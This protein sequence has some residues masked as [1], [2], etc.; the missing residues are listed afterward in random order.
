MAAP[1]L[2][3]RRVDALRPRPATY[4]FRDSELKGFC[5]RVMPSGKKTYLVASQHRGERLWRRL[6]DA[7]AIAEPAAREMARAELAAFREKA[8]LLVESPGEI[9]FEAVAEEVFARYGRHWKPRT[10]AVNRIYLRR[11]ILPFFEGRAIGAIAQ[12][13]VEAWFASLHATPAAA[14]RSVPIL[15][16]IMQQAEAWGYRTASGNPCKGIRRYR[17][18]RMERFLSAA[19]Y[20]RLAEALDRQGRKRRLRVAAVRLI[21]LTGCRKSE[22]LTL[23]W[24]YYREGK[25][26]LPDSKTGPRTIWLCAAAR[27]VLDR[28]PRRSRWVF[29][30]GRLRARTH[31]LDSFWQKLRAEAE[32]DDVR[33]HDARHSYASMALMSGET[34]RTIGV[35]LG[36]HT[37][38]STLKYT[39]L[40]DSAVREALESFSPVLSGDRP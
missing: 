34:I 15:S 1:R 19:E 21:L 28:L 29:P 22:I 23:K 24:S 40:S 17:R 35:L 12:R 37:A 14:N 18:R 39:H 32:L 30:V 9:A 5:V 7:A 3:Q 2:T 26:F 27:D 6:G 4:D 36:H 33:L 10:L 25:L 13:D 8:E 38:S 11:Q 20:R 31:W 16:V